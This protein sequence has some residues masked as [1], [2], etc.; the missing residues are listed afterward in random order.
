MKYIKVEGRVGEENGGELSSDMVGIH[1]KLECK[2]L[3]ESHHH[4]NEYMLTT[5]IKTI[6]IIHFFFQV[7]GVCG[8]KWP[9]P[10]SCPQWPQLVQGQAHLQKMWS[11]SPE[12]HRQ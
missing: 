9:M 1:S 5:D 10:G 8:G 12:D 4:Y 11:S 7:K 6:H 2:C 3:Y